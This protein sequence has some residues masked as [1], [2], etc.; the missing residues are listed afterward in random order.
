MSEATGPAVIQISR[1]LKLWLDQLKKEQ[2]Q[3]LGRQVTYSEIIERLT[4][5]HRPV[6][7]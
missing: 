5:I 1:P 2:E 4:A 6:K 3:E 7:R